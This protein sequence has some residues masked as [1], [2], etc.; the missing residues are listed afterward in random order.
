M[1]VRALEN[2]F[3]LKINCCPGDGTPKQSFIFATPKIKPFGTYLS[4]L[5]IFFQNN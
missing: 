3:Q 2:I 1:K 4:C 5:I